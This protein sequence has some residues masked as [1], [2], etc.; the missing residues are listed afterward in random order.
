MLAS[1]DIERCPIGVRNS[2]FGV[3][4]SRIMDGWIVPANL[5]DD[6]TEARAARDKL[7]AQIVVEDVPQYLS[8]GLQLGERYETSPIISSTATP[9]PADRWDLY[10]PTDRPGARALI[11]GLSQASRSTI[12][13]ARASLC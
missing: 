5:E 1:Y 3:K 8:A 2:Q 12:C 10:T 11:S 7:G 6:T 4:C 13:S 9:E